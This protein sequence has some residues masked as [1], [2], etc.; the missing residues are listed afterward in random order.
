MNDIE[1]Q[2]KRIESNFSELIEIMQLYCKLQD[3]TNFTLDLQIYNKAD[4][5]TEPR[6]WLSAKKKGLGINLMFLTF[7]I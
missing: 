6:I 3:I 5:P 1:Y 4:N 7:M 2:K